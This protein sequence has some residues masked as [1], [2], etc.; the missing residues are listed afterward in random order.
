MATPDPWEAARQRVA[1]LLARRDAVLDETARA[2]TGFARQQ[3]WTRGD[4]ASLWEG[5]TED[6]VR[7]V[8]RE[9]GGESPDTV[10]RDVLGTMA[11]LRDRIVA[12]LER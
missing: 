3:G 2:W 9:R 1:A 10:R 6:L 8:A 4:V 5:L 11:V 12:E 7:R